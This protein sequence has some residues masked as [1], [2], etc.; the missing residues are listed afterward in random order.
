MFPHITLHFV[1]E[2]FGHTIGNLFSYIIK[3]KL[4]FHNLNYLVC[5]L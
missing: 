4:F 5:T 1:K 3:I 2:T